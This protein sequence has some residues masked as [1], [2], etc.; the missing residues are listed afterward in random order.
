MTLIELLNSLSNPHVPNNANLIW[1][2][3]KPCFEKYY[4]KQL[5]NTQNYIELIDYLLNLGIVVDPGT[6]IYFTYEDNSYVAVHIKDSHRS[7]SALAVPWNIFLGFNIEHST[8]QNYSKEDI[9]GHCLWEM[10]Y[11]GFTQDSFL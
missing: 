10:T 3:V 5:H 4:P 11:F 2:K 6:Y 9:I 8:M 1:E 7:W